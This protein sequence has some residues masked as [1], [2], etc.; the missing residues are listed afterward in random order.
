MWDKLKW[1]KFIWTITDSILALPMTTNQFAIYLNVHCSLYVEYIARHIIWTAKSGI[2]LYSWDKVYRVSKK[3]IKINQ[4]LIFKIVNTFNFIQSYFSNVYKF[5]Q[6]IIDFL[7][8]IGSY[9]NILFVLHYE[10]KSEYNLSN[11]VFFVC[12]IIIF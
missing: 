1:F 12:F 11:D 6:N 5:K 10:V 8:K 2:I 3:C 9:R 4:S 7:S